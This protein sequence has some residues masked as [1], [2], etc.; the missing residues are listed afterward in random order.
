[1]YKDL[2]NEKTELII[3]GMKCKSYSKT[4]GQC[5]KLLAVCFATIALASCGNKTDNYIFQTDEEA[6]NAYKSYLS[7]VRNMKTISTER[8]IESV[9]EWQALRDSVYV[10]LAKD[11]ISRPHRNCESTV[12]ML[13]DSLRIEFTRLALSQPRSFADVLLIKEKTS[14]Y[15]LDAE[16]AQAATCA[17][18][19]FRS[20]DSVAPYHGNTKQTVSIYQSYLANTLKSGIDSKDKMLAFIQEEDRL[21]RSFLNHLPELADADLSA[22]TDETE[23]CCLSVFRS[24]EDGNLSHRDALIYTAKRTNRRVVLNALACCDDI[25]QN[26]VKS[27]DQARAYVWMLLQPYI[28]LDGFSM[29]VMSETERINLYEVADNTPLMIANLNKII[30]TDNDQ[31]KVLPELLVKI[32]MISI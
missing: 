14:P 32:M 3:K 23:K 13:H 15:R 29:T 10:C 24:A 12:R 25:S 9:N 22:I 1:M 6:A 26:R 30:G 28:A 7:E 18:P 17:E 16:L 5:A 2:F 19:F 21:F 8:L 20:L 11:T 31:W 27:E 4:R